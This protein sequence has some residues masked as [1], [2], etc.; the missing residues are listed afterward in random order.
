[1]ISPRWLPCAIAVSMV[2]IAGSARGQSL[3]A[4][5]LARIKAATVYIVVVTP[6]GQGGSGSG[7]VVKTIGDDTFIVTNNHVIDFNHKILAA[8][9]EPA[10]PFK[11]AIS[12]VFDSG[13][14]KER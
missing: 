10:T 4:E 7:F 6:G 12:V 3:S 13:N 2:A 9:G 11:A 1:M 5:Q 14:P 8:G